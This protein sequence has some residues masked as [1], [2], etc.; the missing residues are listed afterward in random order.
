MP[1]RRAQHA[2]FT[3]VELLVVIGIIALLIAILLPALS[4]AREQAK[5]I[6]CLTTLRSMHQAAIGHAA[7]H[8]GY[9]PFAGDILGEGS[10]DGVGDPGRW[11]YTYYANEE[12]ST[13]DPHI[14]FIDTPAPLSGSLGK[15]MNLSVDL[16]SAKA[17]K[18]SLKL[19]SVRRAF[20]CPSDTNPI[21][22]ASTICLNG[23]MGLP[24][25]EEVMSYLFNEEVLGL[26]PDWRDLSPAGKVS[27]IRHPAEVFLFCDGRR[28]TEPP[29]AYTVFDEQ[30][31]HDK[32]LYDWYKGRGTN[33]SNQWAWLDETRHR[34]RINVIF[35]DGH[36]ETIEAPDSRYYSPRGKADLQRIGLS[37][38]VYR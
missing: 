35:V 1:Q 26:R 38:G 19:D 30:F 18:A 31:E 16:S 24:S 32:T 5:L 37:R 25:N 23:N 28:G 29:R 7:D 27:M 15:Y 9:M 4:R 36:A 13:N 34:A 2:G 14:P 22:P 12:H 6:Q 3:L 10:A 17:L 11:K 33:Y 20:T 8:R 21:T